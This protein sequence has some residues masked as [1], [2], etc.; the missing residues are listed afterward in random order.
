MIKKLGIVLALFVLMALPAAAQ[1]ELPDPGMTPDSPFYFMDRLF[2]VFQSAE[3]LADERASEMVAMAEKG[4]ENALERARQ[5][6][7]K[8]M[9]KRQ[10]QAEEDE[11]TAEEVSRQASNHLAVLAR[12][13]EQVPEQARA[14]IGRALDDST[15]SRKKGLEELEKKNP[16]RAGAVAEATLQEVMANAPEAAQEGLQRALEAVQRKGPA[17]DAEQKREEE[18]RTE[19]RDEEGR[20]TET[21]EEVEERK[22]EMKE[23]AEERKTQVRDEVTR[24]TQVRDE[25]R[26]SQVRYDREA[27]TTETE[28]MNENGRY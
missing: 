4:N 16:E 5:G 19:A 3:S 28:E 27:E 12:V 10:R 13:R 17:E 24:T 20:T 14:G 2:D 21:R 22:T 26:S 6:Y 11:N 7:Q 9:Q 1:P 18:R 8:A 23:E 25:S 15:N